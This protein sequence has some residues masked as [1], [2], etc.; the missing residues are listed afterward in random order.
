ME[1]GDEKLLEIS[2]SLR[3]Q[4]GSEKSLHEKRFSECF[5]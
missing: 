1:N 4:W 2:Q 3:E 5:E